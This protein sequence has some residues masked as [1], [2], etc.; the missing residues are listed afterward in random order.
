MKKSN[1]L[2]GLTYLFV[3]IVCLIGALNFESRIGSLLAGFAGAGICGGT[4]ILYKYYY[5]MKPENK[6]KYKEKIENDSIEIHD[7][8][9]T[10]LRDKSGRYA[11]IIGLIVISASIVVFSIIG[12]F[13]KI[14][15][16]ELIVLYLAGFLVFQYIT[17]ILIFNH[18]NR[19]Y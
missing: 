8:R 6:P 1:L 19:K 16:S 18:L 12:S 13:N 5:W 11:Y 15:G 4:V 2:V 14:D 7:E 10:M 3:G 9:K 17:G